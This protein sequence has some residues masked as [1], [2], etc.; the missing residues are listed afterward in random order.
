MHAHYDK[1]TGQKQLLQTHLFNVAKSAAKTATI[2]GQQ[3]ILFLLGLY[4]DV[5]KS[6]KSFQNKLK[7]QLPELVNHS[8]AGAK[9]LFDQA[10]PTLLAHLKDEKHLDYAQLFLETIC[11][12]ITAHHGVY[13]MDRLHLVRQ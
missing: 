13:D 9:Y 4:H 6:K 5:G 12:V 7:Y 11:Y 8:S 1:A 10:R 2:I 3:D